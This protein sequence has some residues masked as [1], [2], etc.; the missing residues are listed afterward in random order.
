MKT[1]NTIVLLVFAALASAGMAVDDLAKAFASPPNE[2]KPWCYWWWLN[3]AASKEG[4]TRDFEEMRNKGISG[5]LLFDAGQAGPDAPR[6]P[7]FMSDEWRELYKH[8]VREADRC[9]IVLGVNLCSG[10]NAGGPWVTHEHAAKK[11]VASQ[12]IVKGPGRVTAALPKPAAV[13]EFY[14]DIAVLACPV[15]AG[16]RPEMTLRASSQY[17]HYGPALAEDGED[18]T[19]WVSNGH[20]PGMGPTPAKPEYLQFDL[21]EAWPAAGLFL[22]PYLH[23]APKEIEVQCS[24]DGRTFR[25]LKRLT[26]E[27]QDKVTISFGET[28]AK[29]FRVVFLSSHPF[30]GQ[31]NW[32]VQVA[33][34]ALLSKE[35]LARGTARGR[36]WERSR[37][38]DVKKFMDGNG[39]LNWEV[40]PGSWNI[41]RIGFTLHGNKIKCVGSGPSGLEID[42]MSAEAMEAH[43][44]ETGAKLIADAG[45]LVGKTLQ[46]FHIDS[47]EF[48]VP[49]WTPRMREEFQRRRGYDLLPWLPAVLG[50]TVDNAAETGRFL[51][52]Y[53]RTAADLVAANYYGRLRELTLKGG[54]RGT[55]PESG[56]PFFGHWIDA[57]QCEGINDVPMGEFW[58]RNS[59]PDGPITHHHNPSLKQAA[60]AAHIYGKRDCQAEAFTS[61]GDDWIDDPWS[62][63]DIGDAAFCEGLTRNVL[64]FWIHQPRLDA[65]P[66]FQWA[67]VGTHFDCNLTWWPMSGAWLT[68]LARCQH[69]L[70]QGLFVADFA[71]LQDEAIP[72]FIAPRPDQQPAR[73]A[74]FDYDV[75]NAEVLLTRATAK[76]GRLTLPDGMS[77]RYLVLSHRPDAILS[78]AT[79]KKV[80]QLAEA[81]VTVIREGPLDAVVR[82][83]GLAP[84]IEFRSTSQ[85][86]N[87][88][89]IH[90][91]DGATEIYFISNQSALNAAADV[92]F[93]VA[94]KQ[95]ELWDAVTASIRNLPEWLEE[96]GRT[97]VPLQFAPR[98]SWF[99]VFRNGNRL[100]PRVAA[101][102]NLLSRSERTTLAGPWEVSFDP[103]WGG[104]ER[105]VFEKLADWTA[106]PE[107]G[108]RYYSGTATYRITF[109]SKIQNP[110]SK[111][112]LDLG[113]VKNVARVRLND[114]D[115]GVVWTA[116]WQVDI[117]GALKPGANKLEIEVAN[118]WPNRLIGDATLPKEKRLTVTNVRT[119]DDMSSGS[120]RCQKCEER[121]K[122]GKPAELLSSG[123]LGPVK[124]VVSLR[125]TKQ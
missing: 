125:E 11:L 17:Q 1:R 21:A 93:R 63:K 2:S 61:F 76:D 119:Y 36:L 51:Q 114:R 3:G 26:L 90:R 59:E 48:G 60:C 122:T 38:V 28:R 79:L 116:P 55:H 103:K 33:E 83:D 43:F 47:W 46:Y 77:Y 85:C 44:A 91:R 41:L 24:E 52:D 18:D 4:I 12:T 86:A 16:D 99:V 31:E 58:K 68:Y 70:R 65:K 88:D 50:R 29:H 13:Q 20:K 7:A 117:T 62:M 34:I 101:A 82:A 49:T 81:G 27:T 121:K 109:Q 105:V 123:L 30:R 108:I 87:F 57:L 9:G 118:L 67:H 115:L 53:H 95:P 97:V 78:P 73:P 14:R 54:L 94:G 102:K 74:G 75:L 64:C 104:P 40:P 100:A 10:W 19:R 42:P 5:A 8:A 66:G 124:V 89:W 15:V 56:G 106:R 22:K 37:A 111:I 98:Q 84:D 39:Q 69:M 35:D 72:G 80:N 112:L 107:P 92:V 23:C 71:Y 45:P 25:P 6:G 32:N 96:N 120:Y 113:V 110:K